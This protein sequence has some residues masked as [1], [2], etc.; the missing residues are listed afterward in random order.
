MA[1]VGKSV[2]LKFYHSFFVI[3]RIVNIQTAFLKINALGIRLFRV[4][5]KFLNAIDDIIF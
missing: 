1:Y 5:H 2:F 4:N 3:I